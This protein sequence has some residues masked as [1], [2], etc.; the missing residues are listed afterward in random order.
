MTKL[1]DQLTEGL[2][3]EEQENTEQEQEEEETSG[4]EETEQGKGDGGAEG[5]GDSGDAG[6]DDEPETAADAAKALGLDPNAS[7]KLPSGEVITG[8]EL[9]LGYMREKDYTQKTQELSETR[10]QLDLARGNQ[11]NQ[12][13][14][15]EEEKQAIEL[16]NDNE[17]LKKALDAMDDDDPNKALFKAIISRNDKMINW[18]NKQTVQQQRAQADNDSQTAAE[19]FKKVTF[20]TID[21]EA[22]NYTLPK[23]KLPDGKEI[24]FKKRWQDSVLQ[25]LRDTDQ[26]LTLPEY[27][28]LIRQTGKKAYEEIRSLISAVN[29]DARK[30]K[31]KEGEDEETTGK[32]KKPATSRPENK[33]PVLN[34]RDALNKA[35]EKLEK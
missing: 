35:F 4:G 1:G 17:V 8:A 29:K 20:D 11:S 5:E 6:A 12:G 7:Y 28:A 19:N 22:K 26:E 10:R 23:V 15:T 33:K 30:P 27:K 31:P 9:A 3:E 24:D 18:I 13:Q 21:G 34:V 2:N 32:G 14:Q 25:I 16:E